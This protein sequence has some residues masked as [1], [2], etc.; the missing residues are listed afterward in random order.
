MQSF[1]PH[2][3]KVLVLISM[4]FTPF[5][6]GKRGSSFTL[7]LA[8]VNL[9]PEAWRV[10]VLYISARGDAGPRGLKQRNGV[11]HVFQTG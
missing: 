10:S 9:D 5:M 2:M 8:V 1:A 11:C 3:Q 6:F 4:Y 7:S